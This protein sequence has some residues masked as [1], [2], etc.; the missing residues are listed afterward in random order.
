[1]EPLQLMVVQV[2]LAA[3]SNSILHRN[4]ECRQHCIINACILK[5]SHKLEEKKKKGVHDLSII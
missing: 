4:C 2:S 3:S 1:M 5:V